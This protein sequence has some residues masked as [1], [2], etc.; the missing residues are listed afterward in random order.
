M[1]TAFSYIE[2]RKCCVHY[3]VR[4][5]SCTN[6]KCI[7]FVEE[8]AAHSLACFLG[9]EDGKHIAVEDP[10]LFLRFL[11]TFCADGHELSDDSGRML[12]N[13][14]PTHRASVQD[15]R[16]T[17]KE[18]RKQRLKRVLRAL[19]PFRTRNTQVA[20]KTTD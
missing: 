14:C 11:R 9:R 8:H 5:E 2:C 7:R 12:S 6:H 10:A 20:T 18:K 17:R 19:L 3:A 16:R 15:A 13:V 4:F 1:G